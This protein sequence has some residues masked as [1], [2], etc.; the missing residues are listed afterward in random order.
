MRV[1]AAGRLRRAPEWTGWVCRQVTGGPGGAGR[2]VQG[3]EGP[4]EGCQRC[5]GP[6]P[7]SLLS[8]PLLFCVSCLL[9]A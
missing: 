4:A 1:T 9:T 3:A 7:L 5:E 6:A 8:L 2:A